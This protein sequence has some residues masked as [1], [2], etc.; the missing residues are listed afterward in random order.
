[1][2]LICLET[3]WSC[4]LFKMAVLQIGYISLVL[5]TI[6]IK[7]INLPIKEI[8]LSNMVQVVIKT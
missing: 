4:N 6:I 7:Y 8:V 1:M 5:V 2:I 3:N